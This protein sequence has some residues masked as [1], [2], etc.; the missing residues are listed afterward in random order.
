MGWTRRRYAGVANTAAS[1]YFD[2]P[3]GAGQGRGI[4]SNTQTN[5][6]L[7]IEKNS[8]IHDLKPA[9]LHFLGGVKI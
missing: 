4:W 8:F 3:S 5:A 7:M 1:L 2:S 6:L 9:Y